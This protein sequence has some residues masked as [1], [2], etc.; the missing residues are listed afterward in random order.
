MRVGVELGKPLKNKN[1]E[2]FCRYYVTRLNGKIYNGN[3]AAIKAGYSKKTARTQ[4]SKLLTNPNI[5]QRI[6][7]LKEKAL[8]TLE[9]DQLF[10]LD[11]LKKIITDDIKNYL[12]FG[13]EEVEYWTESGQVKSDQMV[14]K[15][16]NSDDIDTSNI[17]QIKLNE[18][19][20]FEFKLNDKLKAFKELREYLTFYND[21]K[22]ELEKEKFELQKEKFELEKKLKTGEKGNDITKQ[23]EAIKTLADYLENPQPNRTIE[24]EPGESN[25]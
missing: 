16:K 15:L 5:K 4:A 24:D 12:S 10:L 25:E 2:L 17:N 18:K 9:L 8:K 7:E 14:V 23:L 21:N 11:S 3:Q 13:M 19:G 1:H 22:F 20:A 6:D